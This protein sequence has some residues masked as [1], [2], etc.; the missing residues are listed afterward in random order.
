[1]QTQ[2]PHCVIVLIAA[3]EEHVRQV[4]NVLWELAYLYHVL[5][6]VIVQTLVVSYQDYVTQV[7]TA[8]RYNCYIWCILISNIAYYLYTMSY[9]GLYYGYTYSIESCEWHIDR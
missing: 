8:F 5:E 7:I 2:V 9:L 3:Q 6:E 1:M 4:K